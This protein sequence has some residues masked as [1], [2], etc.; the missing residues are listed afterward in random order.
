MQ[1]VAQILP[2][3]V[4]QDGSN[5][6]QNNQDP[7]AVSGEHHQP[8]KEPVGGQFEL[9]QTLNRSRSSCLSDFDVATR[10]VQSP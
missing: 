8:W 1:T 3:Q 2:F 9:V 5:E 7:E 10:P 4:V 6:H